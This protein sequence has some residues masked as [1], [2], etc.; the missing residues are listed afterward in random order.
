MKIL[1]INNDNNINGS[2]IA[3]M[4]IVYELSKR[5]EIRVITPITNNMNNSL[6]INYFIKNNIKYYS[7]DYCL[8]VYPGFRRNF[9]LWINDTLNMIKKTIKV[10]KQ[11]KGIIEDFKPNIVHTNNGPIDIALNP[12]KDKNVPHIWHLREY[13]DLGIGYEIFPSTKLWRKK[14]LSSGN[15]NVAITKCIYD[16][17]NL[18]ECDK[19]IYD[20]PINLEEELPENNKKEKY[21]LF[22]G[23]VSQEG[24]GFYDALVAFN[25]I[26]KRHNDYKLLAAG[27]F[28]SKT[29]YGAQILNFIKNHGLDN[30]VEL[31]GHRNDV[32]RLMNKATALLVTSYYEGFGFTTAEAMFCDCLVLGRNTTGTK[33]QFDNGFNKYGTDIGLRFN[34]TEELIHCMER[35]I[36]EDTTNIRKRAKLIVKELYNSKQTCENLESYYQKI[37][38]IHQFS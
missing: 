3:L 1:Y 31:L 18:R 11:I 33:E 21:F 10:R 27:P 20:G 37:N 15:Y 24:K 23:V 19:I 28:Y 13:S 17:Y 6:L 38:K 4:N 14:I 7:L 34:T 32:F 8:T 36:I 22:V 12:C 9:L 5:H 16:Y 30:S 2:T 25:E 35:A 26:K 29:H